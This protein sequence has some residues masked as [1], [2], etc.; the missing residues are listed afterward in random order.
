MEQTL[1]QRE[2]VWRVSR[3]GDI[4]K[5]IKNRH[6]TGNYP[7]SSRSNYMRR[8]VASVGFVLCRFSSVSQDTVE[9]QMI[10]R[11]MKN[12]SGAVWPSTK[13]R[14]SARRN[15]VISQVV[16]VTVGFNAT[17][18]A[19]TLLIPAGMWL[20]LGLLMLGS[21]FT[22]LIVKDILDEA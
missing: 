5:N 21:A 13:R 7:G 1:L 9:V 6:K 10:M 18:Y 4:I 3:H 19:L 12:V 17:V 15:R 22:S 8:M 16:A 2:G 14:R 11:D 20:A